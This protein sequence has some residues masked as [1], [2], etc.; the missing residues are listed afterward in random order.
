MKARQISKSVLTLV[1]VVSIISIAI[2]VIC[3]IPIFFLSPIIAIITIAIGVIVP[4]IFLL[5]SQMMK[6]LI[7]HMELQTSI[8]EKNVRE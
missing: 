4:V 3:C 7:Y 6:D 1:E 8:L 2:T 5:A